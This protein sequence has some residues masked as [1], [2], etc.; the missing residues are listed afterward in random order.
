MNSKLLPHAPIHDSSRQRI[1]PVVLLALLLGLCGSSVAAERIWD[2]GARGNGW[3]DIGNWVGTGV[4]VAGDDLRFPAG[5]LRPSNNND[6]PAGTSFHLLTY[7]GAGYTASGNE[8]GLTG[9]IL[10]SHGAGNTLVRPITI[11][12][13][14][15]VHLISSCAIIA[16]SPVFSYAVKKSSRDAIRNT[17]RQPPPQ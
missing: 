15:C 5:A 12:R 7:A 11:Q 10:V 4:P 9:G 14:Y 13:T 3:N 1:Q 17:S 2:G 8:V 6:F 16:F